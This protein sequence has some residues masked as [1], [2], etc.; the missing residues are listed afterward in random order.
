MEQDQRQKRPDAP[1]RIG[2]EREE[3]ASGQPAGG[4]PNQAEPEAVK[5]YRQLSDMTKPD[6]E[7]PAVPKPDRAQPSDAERDHATRTVAKPDRASFAGQKQ[8]RPK[9]ASSSSGNGQPS[10]GKSRRAPAGPRETALEVLRRVEEEGAYSSLTLSGVLSDTRLSRQD[11]ALATE[12]VYGTIQRL[13]TI[14]HVLA[15]RVKG[16]PDKIAPWVRCLLRM[17]YYQLRWLDRVPPHAA[18]NEAVRIAKSRGHAGIASLVNGVLRSLLREGLAPVLPPGLSAAE[19][20]ALEHSHPAWLVE[21]WIAACGEA[22]AAAICEANNLPPHAAA[23][24]NRL[25]TSRDALLA[26]MAAAGIRA[27][28]SPLCEDGI[29]AEK[30]G[31]LAETRWYREGKLSIQDESA[32]LVSVVA[33]PSPGMAVLDCCAAPGGKAAH[34]AEIMGNRGKVVANDIHPH[35]RKLIEDHKARLGLSIIET[36][37]ADALE[38][39]RHLPENSLDVV[40]LDAPCSGLGV[41]RRK[42]EIKWNKTPQDIAAL[43]DLQQRLLREAARLVKPGGALVYST[44][45]ITPEENEENILRFLAENPSFAPDPD[46][47]QSALRPLQEKGVLPEPFRGWAQILPHHFGSDGFFIA[48]LRKVP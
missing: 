3:T 15:R 23:R 33:N 22:A 14:D 35:K 40:L 30:S 19:R 9:P 1:D 32:M 28:P 17:S 46:W 25:R 8:A 37:T 13:N 6:H 38:L 20:I 42:P 16:W 11:A 21:R 41:I 10:A 44:C 45:T 39:T 34:L 24:V 43:A 7:Q 27:R 47:P 5:A 29:V 2:T 36:M 26:E 31:S 4:A 48:R 18:V 12:L